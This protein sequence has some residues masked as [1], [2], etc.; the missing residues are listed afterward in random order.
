MEYGSRAIELLYRYY[1]GEIFSFSK[2]QES[3]SDEDDENSVDSATSSNRLIDKKNTLSGI[4]GENL[5]PK[6][7]LPP[8]LLPIAEVKAPKLDWVGTSFGLHSI[9]TSGMNFLYLRQTKNELTGENS[10][11]KIRAL[12]KRTGFDDAWLPAFVC[13]AKRRIISLL[14]GIFRDM[15]A[16]LTM[17]VLEQFESTT[18]TTMRHYTNQEASV[19]IGQRS[20]LISDKL[21]TSELNYI[22]TPHDLKRV[23]L[24]GRNLCDHY[25]IADLLLVPGRLY[26]TGRLGLDINLSSLQASIL[27]GMGEWVYRIR[28][29]TSLQRH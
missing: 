27:C 5:L 23:E 3:S 25:L 28:L 2:E 18:A 8:L 4:Q 19:A 22:L 6:K 15:D 13:D 29:L 11:I 26:F 12:P 1:N 21:A 16:K 20:G 17:S 9:Y 24:Y 7:G 10:A 14:A